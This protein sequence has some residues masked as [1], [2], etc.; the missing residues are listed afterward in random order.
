MPFAYSPTTFTIDDD[1]RGL[2]VKQVGGPGHGVFAGLMQSAKWQF[3][4]LVMRSD[5][6]DRVALH[7]STSPL[8]GI[9]DRVEAPLEL[10]RE[11]ALAR[12][13]ALY[14]TKPGDA[15]ELITSANGGV[16]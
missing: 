8:V 2:A 12:E 3:K 1:E 16:S 4:F 5:S 15:D 10:A 9:W 6:D 11:A 13:F 14:G 7:I